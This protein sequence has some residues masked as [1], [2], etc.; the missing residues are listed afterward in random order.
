MLYIVTTYDNFKVVMRCQG[1][2][3]LYTSIDGDVG[4]ITQT[5]GQHQYI[6]WQLTDATA[7]AA[8]LQDYPGAQHVTKIAN[9]L[10]DLQLR[11]APL[12]VNINDHPS[13]ATVTTVP[14]SGTSVTLLAPNAARRGAIVVNSTGVAMFVKLG[15]DASSTSYAKRLDPGTALEQWEVPFQYSGIVTGVW[16]SAGAGNAII[17]ELTI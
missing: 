8:F 15:P 16:A 11:A 7:E 3:L 12:L 13:T 17:T 6:V 4:M 2:Q 5:E 14:R 1:I 10:T 9:P